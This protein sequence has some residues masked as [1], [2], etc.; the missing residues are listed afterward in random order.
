TQLR[1][2][3]DQGVTVAR[4]AAGQIENAFAAVGRGSSGRLFA[5][6]TD[7]AAGLVDQFGRPLATA[8]SPA[9]DAGSKAGEGGE[10]AGRAAQRGGHGFELSTQQLARFAA[11]G[12]QQVIPAADGQRVAIESGF[13]AVSRLAGGYG[14]IAV[15]GAGLAAIL[16]G[17]LYNAWVG[18]A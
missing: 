17:T 11:I 5:G 18:Q 15:V 10:N 14:S 4:G 3:L 2:G 16:G 7:Q 8:A 9:S 12:F 13:I 6:L 1:T